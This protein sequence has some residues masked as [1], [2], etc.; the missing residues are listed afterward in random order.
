MPWTCSDTA[1]QP[2]TS[3]RKD[4]IGSAGHQAT[5]AGPRRGE[6]WTLTRPPRAVTSSYRATAP[7]RP[8]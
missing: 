8:A 3:T 7:V 5:A 6:P 1:S 2:A 4:V